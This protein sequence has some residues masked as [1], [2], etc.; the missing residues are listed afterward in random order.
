MLQHSAARAATN[1]DFAKKIEK[2]SSILNTNGITNASA[3]QAG[4]GSYP[5]II[6]I[7]YAKA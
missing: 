2:F 5:R 6:S 3:E 7:R 1:F 4:G